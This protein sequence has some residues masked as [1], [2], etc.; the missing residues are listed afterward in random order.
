MRVMTE[1]DLD[2][3]NIVLYIKKDNKIIKMTLDR[4]AL[5]NVVDQL[6]N[7]LVRQIL[8]LLGWKVEV[9]EDTGDSPS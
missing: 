6:N 5:D 8:N 9:Y 4:K 7:F 3:L 1:L 2:T